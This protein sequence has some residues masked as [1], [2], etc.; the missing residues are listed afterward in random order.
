MEVEQIADFEQIL[1]DKMD[2]SHVEVFE[3]IVEKK[4]LTDDIEVLL[5]KC[6]EAAVSEVTAQSH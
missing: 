5:K 1:Y 2:S 4:K 3:T 6:I